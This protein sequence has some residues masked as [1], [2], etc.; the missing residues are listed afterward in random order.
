MMGRGHRAPPDLGED[1]VMLHTHDGG[2]FRLPDNRT[3]TGLVEPRLSI[4][5]LLQDICS[6]NP[7]EAHDEPITLSLHCLA[8][9]L[10]LI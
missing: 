7:P 2:G 8:E 10:L 9:L 1:Y 3:D 6:L 4:E 5:V